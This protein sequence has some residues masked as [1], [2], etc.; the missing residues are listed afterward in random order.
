MTGPQC[1]TWM[2]ESVWSTWRSDTEVCHVSKFGCCSCW[3]LVACLFFRYLKG[4]LIASVLT[5]TTKRKS[6]LI[7]Q[8]F[9]SPMFFSPQHADLWSRKRRE[10]SRKKNTLTAL[11]SFV[12]KRK[13]SC[14]WM[15]ASPLLLLSWVSCRRWF[16]KPWKRDVQMAK[17]GQKTVSEVL[18]PARSFAPS[19]FW[20]QDWLIWY[21]WKTVVQSGL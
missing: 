14:G 17:N 15:S 19:S 1:P 12:T 3:W 5:L 10:E 16:K 8:H 7:T 9:W 4:F 21:S 6:V 2:T 20:R 18:G 13:H 11:L